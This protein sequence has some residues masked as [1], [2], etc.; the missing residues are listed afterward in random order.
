MSKPKRI[1]PV[2]TEGKMESYLNSRRRSLKAELD[3]IYYTLPYDEVQPVLSQLKD[4]VECLSE[5]GETHRS[6]ADHS[7]A[8]GRRHHTKAA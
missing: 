6:H 5:M 2:P 1:R 3:R 7:Q 4:T 8:H